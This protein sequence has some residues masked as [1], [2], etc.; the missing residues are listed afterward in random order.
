MAI[1]PCVQCSFSGVVVHHADVGVLI[2]ERDI[3]VL[4]CGGVGV[5]GKVDLGAGQ[6]GVGDVKGATDHKGLPSAA[7]WK[8]R[9]PALKYFH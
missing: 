9:V 2:V 1:V 7:F 3:S 6:V 4:I 8:T 5:V